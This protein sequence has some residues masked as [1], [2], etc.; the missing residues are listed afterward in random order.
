MSINLKPTTCFECHNG[1]MTKIYPV[2]SYDFN[3]EGYVP[4]YCNHCGL[5]NDAEELIPETNIIAKYSNHFK[6]KILQIVC[7]HGRTFDY[8]SFKTLFNCLKDKNIYSPFDFAEILKQ[9]ADENNI[10]LDFCFVVNTVYAH[11]D[12]SCMS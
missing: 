9:T 6:K 3:K 10:S 1:I 7:N 8:K 2:H 4:Q 5:C 12:Y 11:V